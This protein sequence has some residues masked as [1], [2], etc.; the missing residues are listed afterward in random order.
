MRVPA[1]LKTLKMLLIGLK[2]VVAKAEKTKT[3]KDAKRARAF[4]P[5]ELNAD[6]A[7]EEECIPAMTIV[8]TAPREDWFVK[9]LTLLLREKT[10]PFSN[11]PAPFVASLRPPVCLQAA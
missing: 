2:V 7:A 6:V 8:H 3:A 4:K 5:L 1:D 9:E 10:K 11:Y